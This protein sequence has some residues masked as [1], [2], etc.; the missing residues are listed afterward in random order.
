MSFGSV[1]D[2]YDR[3]RPTYPPELIDDLMAAGPLDVLDVGCGTGKVARLFAARGCTVTGIEP[4]ER[5]AV[6]ARRYGLTVESGRF[7]EW[8]PA[9]RSFD[10]LV[11]GQAWHWVDKEAGARRAAVVLRPGGRFA[12]FWNVSHHDERT[13]AALDPC[14]ERFAPELLATSV[15]LGRP[16]NM[17]PSST[18]QAM[19]AAPSFGAVE[20]KRYRWEQVLSAEEWVDQLGTHSD[21][22]LLPDE[23]RR[24]L[25]DCVSAA[26][27]RLGGSVTISYVTTSVTTLRRD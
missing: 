22:I 17:G 6:V 5:M 27:G 25:L 2:R 24:A 15:T 1:A 23:R 26:I 9:G 12:A 21:H 7:E 8:D 4:D 13:R 19:A 11:S 10:L 18:E 20:K 3:S 16:G 14:Y